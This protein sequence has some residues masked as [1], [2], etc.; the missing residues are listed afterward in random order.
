M[1]ELLRTFDGWMFSSDQCT[2][3][4][5]PVQSG[6]W[7]RFRMRGGRNFVI[8]DVKASFNHVVEYGK[9]VQKVMWSKD[10]ESR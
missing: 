5:L 9:K 6:F 3:K 10:Y 8:W 4:W 7:E 1:N 2:L